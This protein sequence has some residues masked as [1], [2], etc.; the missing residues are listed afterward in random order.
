MFRTIVDPVLVTHRA[1]GPI[2][3]ES[4]ARAIRTWLEDERFDPK[5]PVLWDIR[6]QPV[7]ISPHVITQGPMKM[8]E[9]TDRTRAGARSAILV[10]TFEGE[11]A[12]RRMV[13][14]FPWKI[15]WGVFHSHTEAF[16]WL[17][18]DQ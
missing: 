8:R 14:R 4:I 12:A 13:D 3:L 2:T 15:Q 7:L 10:N 1:V 18:E 6:D 5:V 17:T 9:D 11:L 16:A